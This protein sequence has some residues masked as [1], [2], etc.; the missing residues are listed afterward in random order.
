MATAAFP[1]SPQPGTQAMEQLLAAVPQDTRTTLAALYLDLLGPGLEPIAQSLDALPGGDAARLLH[2][3]AG[4]AA[5][6]QDRDVA[7]S[8]RTMEYAL[9]AGDTAGA[10]ALWPALQAAAARSRA[11]LAQPAG[12]SPCRAA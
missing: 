7:Q 5:M 8:A 12:N 6:L 9:L 3:L 1:T 4:G 11:V 2:K 10:L